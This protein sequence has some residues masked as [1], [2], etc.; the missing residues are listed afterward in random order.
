MPIYDRTQENLCVSDA[1]I[2]VTRRFLLNSVR[3]YA[4]NGEVPRG[5]A[6]PATFMVRAVSLTLPADA[7]WE[8]AGQEHM[9]AVLGKDFGYA[10]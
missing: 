1:G 9:T 2:A 8:E 5:A 3:A 7:D 6:D 4:E 10:P